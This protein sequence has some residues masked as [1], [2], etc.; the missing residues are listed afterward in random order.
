MGEEGD[1]PVCLYS[2]LACA[3]PRSCVSI[4]FIPCTREEEIFYDT[5]YSITGL[6]FNEV[7]VFPAY[8]YL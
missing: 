2:P 7:D 6:L 8:S 5:E 3:R 1:L 4:V